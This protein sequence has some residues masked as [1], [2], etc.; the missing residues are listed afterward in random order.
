[1][2]VDTLEFKIAKLKTYLNTIGG[3][4]SA[5]KMKKVAINRKIYQMEQELAQ[6][7]K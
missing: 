1:M 3:N 7:K 4:S 6:T 5:V 2:T